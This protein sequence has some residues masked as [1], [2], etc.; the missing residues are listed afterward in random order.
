MDKVDKVRVVRGFFVVMA[1][2]FVVIAA[3]QRLQGHPLVDVVLDA[4][5]WSALSSGI[6]TVARVYRWRKGQYCAMCGDVP[7]A[8]P[9]PRD[10]RG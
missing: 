9:P 2:A 7:A 3:A 4:L 1:I 8:A 10:V 5:L 6:F